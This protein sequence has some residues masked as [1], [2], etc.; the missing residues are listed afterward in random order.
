LPLGHD[1]CGGIETLNKTVCNMVRQ[2]PGSEVWQAFPHGSPDSGHWLVLHSGRGLLAPPPPT[3][4][5][6]TLLQSFD[7]AVF[8]RSVFGELALSH[9][10]CCTC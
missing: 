7:C 4:A 2:F 8:L 5:V 10:L 9:W 6:T 1:A 3:P